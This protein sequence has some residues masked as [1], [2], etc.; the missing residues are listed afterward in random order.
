MVLVIGAIEEDDT[1]I[2]R[3]YIC[4]LVVAEGDVGAAESSTMRGVRVVEAGASV[5][6]STPG[7]GA[8]PQN[9]ATAT[10]AARPHLPTRPPIRRKIGSTPTLRAGGVRSGGSGR[11][12][13]ELHRVALL[14][15]ARH[16]TGKATL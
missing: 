1:E 5:V 4:A 15:V 3:E 2:G 13:E 16:L 12:C 14:E 7:A 11:E 9:D 6:S 10:T 8:G